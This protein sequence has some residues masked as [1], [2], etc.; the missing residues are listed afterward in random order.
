MNKLLV[1]GIVV[2]AAI[3]YVLMK[4][5]TNSVPTAAVNLPW[6]VEL[7]SD[8]TSSVFGIQLEHTRV[9]EL[10]EALGI[11]YELAII[12]DSNDRN[13]LEI[14]YSYFSAGPIKGKLIAQVSADHN[15][16]EAMQARAS[17]SS[18][19][20]SGSRKFMLN[21]TDLAQIQSWTINSLS[22]IPAANLDEEIVLSRFGQPAQRITTQHGSEHF[23]YP[24]I[25]VDIALNEK[26]KE[27]IQYV[28]PRHFDQLVKPLQQ[29]AA[30]ATEAVTSEVTE[31]H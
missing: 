30:K 8:E 18:Y 31:Q 28:A 20:S 15:E 9:D 23:L 6:Q 5:S 14:Y 26:A 17:S 7:H 29:E 21:A 11:E 10:I 25:G 2:A 13:G 24:N 19:T 16:L 27:L 22:L 1:I 12:S 3:G 4:P